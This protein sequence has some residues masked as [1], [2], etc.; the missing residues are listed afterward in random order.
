ME[1]VINIVY[2]HSAGV[3]VASNDYIPLTLEAESLDLLMKQARIE[4]KFP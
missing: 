1:Y 4:Y 3:W 2:D